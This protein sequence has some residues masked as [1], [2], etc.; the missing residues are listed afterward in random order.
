LFNAITKWST[1]LCNLVE[2]FMR[3]Q[4]NIFRHCFIVPFTL[5]AE[6]CSAFPHKKSFIYVDIDPSLTFMSEFQY[7]LHVCDDGILI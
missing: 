1:A 4:Y 5:P 7:D 3:Q 6:V 2:L